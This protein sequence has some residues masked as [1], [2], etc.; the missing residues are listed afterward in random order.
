MAAIIQPI[1]SPR[2]SLIGEETCSRRPEPRDI[3]PGALRSL[4]ARIPRSLPALDRPTAPSSR[5]LEAKLLHLAPQGGLVN[6]QLCCRGR[7]IEPVAGQ[8]LPDQLA[9]D[10]LECLR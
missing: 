5:K 4:R 9:F 1:L 7:A 6:S 10:V 8:S 3:T 2:G